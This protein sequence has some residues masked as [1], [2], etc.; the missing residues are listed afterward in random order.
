MGPTSKG[1]EGVVGSKVEGRERRDKGG[2]RGR[3]AVI[4]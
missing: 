4:T 2:R 3:G 1:R